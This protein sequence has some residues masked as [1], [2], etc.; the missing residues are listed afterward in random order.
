MVWKLP[1]ANAGGD[2]TPAP[3]GS[4]PGRCIQIIDMGTAK[5]NFKSA[6]GREKMTH[7][8]R[9]TFELMCDEVMGDG[10]PFTIS[11]SVNLT[12][13]EKAGLQVF[14]TAWRGRAFTADDMENFDMSRLLGMAC[15]VS[16][17]HKQSEALG[18]T[19]AQLTSVTMPPKGF[20]VPKA[21]N[22]LVLFNMSDENCNPKTIEQL[23]AKTQEMIKATPE[24]RNLMNGGAGVDQTPE[25]EAEEDD[26]W[27]TQAPPPKKAQ[28][29]Q[30]KQNISTGAT[31]VDPNARTTKKPI[32]IEDDHVPF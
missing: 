14:L 9:F 13:G 25:V 21:V 16:I 23:G 22:P 3:F 31:R 24:W 6:D 11:K 30:P 19:Y 7:T 18:K 1:P 15:M 27:E 26:G 5:S 12:M 28:S 8:I 29:A 32:E 10:R 17:S 2:F 4:H 20:A